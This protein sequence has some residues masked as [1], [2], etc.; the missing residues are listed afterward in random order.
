MDIENHVMSLVR[1]N[2]KLCANINVPQPTIPLFDH[3][4]A[5]CFIAVF[6]NMKGQEKCVNENLVKSFNLL[7]IVDLPST[8]SLKKN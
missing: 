3:A 5:L 4:I 2:S 8:P 6:C 1:F 7:W